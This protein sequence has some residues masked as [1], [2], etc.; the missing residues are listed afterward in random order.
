MEVLRVLNPGVG[1]SFQDRGRPSWRKFGVPVGGV[2]DFH[3][4]LCANRLLD[5]SVDAVVVELLLQGARFIAL[6]ALWVA[7]TGAEMGCTVPT[8]RA[9]RLAAGQTIE[10]PRNESGVWAYVAVESGFAAPRVLGSASVN[11]RARIGSVLLSND[12]LQSV[13]HQ[14]FRLPDGIG[15]RVV[16]AFERRD[17]RVT[18]SLR[19]WPAPQYDAFTA[20]DRASLFE[21]PWLVSPQSDRVGYRFTGEPLQTRFAQIVS[22]PVRVG[23]IQV[24]ENGLPIVTMRDGPTVGGYPKIGVLDSADVSVL[25][26][27]RPGQEIRFQP[28]DET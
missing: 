3:A 20:T 14:A 2:M 12:V 4:A 8:W 25:A 27:C 6:R 28:V 23:T 11:P 15:G 17:Y 16:P 24:P 10:F 13:G 5:N 22:E 21:R 26:Q 7:V 9:V 18:R 1:A 19:V